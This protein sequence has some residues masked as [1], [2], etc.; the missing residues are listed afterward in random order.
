VALHLEG[1]YDTRDHCWTEVVVRGN[2]VPRETLY[3]LPQEY[4][5]SGTQAP[6]VMKTDVGYCWCWLSADT[7][8]ASLM[9]HPI[10]LGVRHQRA[11]DRVR[12]FP[13][14]VDRQRDDLFSI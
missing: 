3:C 6:L 8:Q 1:R 7:V 14:N 9:A 13:D 5:Q 10:S 11:V 4:R 12:Y 2:P